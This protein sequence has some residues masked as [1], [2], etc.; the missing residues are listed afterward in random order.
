MYISKYTITLNTIDWSKCLLFYC[1]WISNVNRKT[2]EAICIHN[3]HWSM[4]KYIG[5]GTFL[6]SCNNINFT[7]QWCTLLSR[8]F[9]L[10]Q[11]CKYS[12][13][14]FDFHLF[15]GL[16]LIQL[17]CTSFWRG[18]KMR[19]H[20]Y[21]PRLLWLKATCLIPFSLYLSLHLSPSFLSSDVSLSLSLSLSTIRLSSL[22]HIHYLAHI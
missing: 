9:P 6:W 21:L 15:V 13:V 8:S 17:L 16:V 14:L 2:T 22:I 20:L 18:M 4:L 19:N 10:L 11:F 12:N 5:K 7:I 1:F 3:R